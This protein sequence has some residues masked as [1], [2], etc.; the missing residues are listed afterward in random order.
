MIVL[1]TFTI[2][3]LLIHVLAMLGAYYQQM[4]GHTFDRLEQ[5]IILIVG[6]S[7]V[8]HFINLFR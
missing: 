1:K 2:V 3:L 6:A 4:D 8:I 5:S 7:A